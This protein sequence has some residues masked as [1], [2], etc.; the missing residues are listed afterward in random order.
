MPT[1]AQ[2]T[3][4]LGTLEELKVYFDPIRQKILRLLVDQ[5]KTVK[6]IADIMD[7]PFKRLYYQFG[8]LEQH[9]FICVTQTRA[10]SG[11]VDEKWYQAVAPHIE[12]SSDLTNLNAGSQALETVL[13]QT[14]TTTANEIR[15]SVKTGTI[16]LQNPILL[17]ERRVLQL[18]LSEAEEFEQQFEAL[19]SKFEKRQKFNGEQTQ[20]YGMTLALYPLSPEQ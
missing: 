17:L 18:R 20:F 7:V 3:L 4:T 13:A 11:A 10:Y 15:D 6:E 19:V 12:V 16:D 9:G 2:Q 5:P 1:L 8:L 14:L